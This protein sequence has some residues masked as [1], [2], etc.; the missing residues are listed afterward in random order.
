MKFLSSMFAL[1][2]TAIVLTGCCCDRDQCCDSPC[3]RPCAPRPCCER[4]CP[5]PCAR[6]CPPPCCDYNAGY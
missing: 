1:M 3:A 2:A 6:P 5:Q 4:P